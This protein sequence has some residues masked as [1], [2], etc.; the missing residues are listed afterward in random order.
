MRSLV[1]RLSARTSAA[2]AALVLCAVTLA[3][4]NHFENSFQFDDFNTIKFNVYIRYLDSIPKFFID[5]ATQSVHPG[6]RTWRPLVATSL[7]ID[8]WLGGGLENTFYF[9]LSTFLWFLVQLSLMYAL[10]T[11]LLALVRPDPRNQWIAWFAVAWYGL[12]PAVAETINYIIQRA[13]VLSTLG[14]VAALVVYVRFPERRR[15]G[16]YLIP[17]ALGTLAK[18][19][20]LIFPLILLA[21]VFLF[22]QSVSV[23]GFLTSARKSVPATALS[24]ALAALSSVMTAKS[25][26]STRLPAYDYLITQPYV[27]LRYFR[28]FFLPTSLSADTDLR[29]FTSLLRPEALMGFLFL[30]ALVLAVYATA[31]RPHTRPIS[32]GLV[33]FLLAMA[34]TSLY[35][36][37]E[38]EN[39]HRMFFPFVGL[40]I[41]ATWAGSLLLRRRPL[42]GNFRPAVAAGLGGLLL[43]CALG[44]RERNEVWHTPESL[45]R[46]VTVK[47]P[48]NGRGLLNYGT[49]LMDRGAAAPAL[50]CFERAIPLLA[51]DSMLEVNLGVANG[52]L[53]HDTEAERHFRRAIQLDNGRVEPYYTYARW[54]KSKSRD[55]EAVAALSAAISLNPSFMNARHL[56]LKVYAEHGLWSLLKSFGEES[57]K[58]APDDPTVLKYLGM[59]RQLAGQAAYAEALARS[60]PTPENYLHLSSLYHRVGRYAD[61][62]AAAKE[63]LRLRPDLAEAY[64]NIAAAYLS[65]SQWDQAIRA[66]SE[67]L[68][69][70]PD[71]QFARNNLEL[72]K[73]QKNLPAGGR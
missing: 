66:A 54:L 61:C 29:A 42:G 4:S 65:T 62:I 6:S 38:V 55:T 36:L 56:L 52:A 70:K 11:R 25:F 60:Q 46:D 63:A 14:V 67:A 13:D 9:H 73:S 33:W 71:F 72:A 68:R 21:Y 17:F 37:G 7:A 28:S 48:G 59:E 34:P 58:L 50:A 41:A 20:A 8:Y 3:Y 26:V 32:F 18:A 51:N 30:G 49:A 23:G 22:E 57:L 16:L 35:P 45:W 10:Y 1:S 24:L 40:A 43:L 69:I 12:H 19:P 47:S 27:A 5:A 15:S 64:N 53:N 2:I 31:K 39:D 44:T